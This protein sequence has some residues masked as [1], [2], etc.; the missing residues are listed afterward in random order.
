MITKIIFTTCFKVFDASV[1]NL[2]FYYCGFYCLKFVINVKWKC[3]ELIYSTFFR[4][5]YKLSYILSCEHFTMC[6]SNQIKL[7]RMSFV[8]YKTEYQR[9]DILCYYMIFSVI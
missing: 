7:L 2:H 9:K 1:Q 4:D 6:N 3:P 5:S 8:S